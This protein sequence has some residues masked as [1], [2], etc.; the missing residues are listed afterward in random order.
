MRNGDAVEPSALGELV[1]H[2]L[3]FAGMEARSARMALP[4]EAAVSRLLTLPPMPR[5]D[6]LRAVHYAAERHIPFPLDRARWSWDVVEHS[7]EAI[8]V[9]VVAAWR[10]VVDRYAEV[11]RSAG[12]EPGVLEPRSIAVARAVNQEYAVLVDGGQRRL[13][14]T[15]MVGGQPAL[16]DGATVGPEPHDRREALD[17]LLQRAFRYQ[18]GSGGPTRLAPVLFAGELETAGIQLPVAGGAVS[19][20]LNGHLPAAPNGFPAGRFLANLG[21]AMRAVQ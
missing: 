21:L 13:H 6:L 10:D 9:Y 8:K 15:L 3:A 19:E 7:P 12:L 4:D 5:R 11:A 16:V 2:S 20:V 1:K 17:R 14:L 18:S